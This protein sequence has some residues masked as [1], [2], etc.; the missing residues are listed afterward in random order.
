[1]VDTDLEQANVVPV[2]ANVQPVAIQ[3][4]DHEKLLRIQSYVDALAK[5]RQ[6][7]GRLVQ[8]LGNMREEANR[9]EV[10]L[11]E[12]RRALSDKYNLEQMGA[13][14]WALDFERKEFVKTAP[15][16]PVIP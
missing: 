2:D 11:A 1:M 9:V 12:A 15:G 4:E 3:E 16:T 5:Y 13:G 8:L 14:Q 6:E 7:M 10:E